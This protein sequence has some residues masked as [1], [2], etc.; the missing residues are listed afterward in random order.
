MSDCSS[1]KKYFVVVVAAQMRG[2]LDK[3]SNREHR[4]EAAC[5]HT[6]SPH[7]NKHRAEGTAW[8]S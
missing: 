4:A 7:C 8:Q 6:Y 2:C 5:R 3:L 1:T